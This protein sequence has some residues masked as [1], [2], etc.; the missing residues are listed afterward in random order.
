MKE[1]QADGNLSSIEPKTEAN[2]RLQL[3]GAFGDA[4]ISPI[5]ALQRG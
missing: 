4:L 2:I 5:E 1:E 3:K